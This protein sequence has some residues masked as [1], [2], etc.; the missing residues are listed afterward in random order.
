MNTA[1]NEINNLEALNQRNINNNA[2]LRK[3]QM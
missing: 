2:T 1:L 3:Y